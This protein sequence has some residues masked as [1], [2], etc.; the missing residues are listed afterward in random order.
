MTFETSQPNLPELFLKG[1]LVRC[2][3][4]PDAP[5][6]SFILGTN[7]DFHFGS[8]RAGVGKR[9]LQGQRQPPAPYSR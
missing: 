1:T 7:L 6:P 3:R 9:R 5:F 8:P 2:L 4:K